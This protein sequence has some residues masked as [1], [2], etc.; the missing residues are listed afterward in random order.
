MEE[1]WNGVYPAITTKFRQDGS[2]DYDL[3]NKNLEYQIECGIHGLV[4]AGSL[5]ETSTLNFDEKQELLT[6]TIETVNGRIP[7][8]LNIAEQSTREAILNA[9]YAEK[10][11]ASGLMLL[12]PMRYKADDRETT[13]YFKDVAKSTSLPIM[14]YNNPVDYGIEITFDMFEEMKFL[15]LLEKSRLG[16]PTAAPAQ[17]TFHCATLN[18]GLLFSVIQ[19]RLPV[20]Q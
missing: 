7:I 6:N 11:G 8:I 18:K 2:I 4:L 20:S 10:S 17:E 5:G 12:P 13:T 9:E 3:F 14:I 19:G 15:S 16:D 1:L